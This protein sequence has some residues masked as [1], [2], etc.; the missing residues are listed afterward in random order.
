MN[1]LNFEE[2]ADAILQLIR[3]DTEDYPPPAGKR[4]FGSCWIPKSCI[5]Q[6]CAIKNRYTSIR[7]RG[8]NIGAHVLAT[9]LLYKTMPEP[10]TQTLHGCDRKCCRNPAHMRRGTGAE[11]AQDA[12]DK[13]LMP[14][15]S[16]GGMPHGE[17]NCRA[18]MSDPLAANIKWC[19]SNQALWYSKE[20][21]AI[22]TPVDALAIIYQKSPAALRRMQRGKSWRHLESERPTRLPSLA[23]QTS[24]TPS[25]LIPFR[26]R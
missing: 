25:A 16:D 8:D 20:I 9:F 26:S 2:Y 23:T 18:T 24:S 7:F 3:K 19:F 13:G 17:N 5:S 10:G 11:N 4:V 6:S 21:E 1:A 22:Y 12:F 14:V 15:P